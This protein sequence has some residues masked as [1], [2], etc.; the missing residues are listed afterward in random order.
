MPLNHIGD[1]EAQTLREADRTRKL[2]ASKIVQ[3]DYL[4]PILNSFVEEKLF[5]D[6]YIIF[7]QTEADL[8][9][10]TY[11]KL[12]EIIIKDL[13]RNLEEYEIFFRIVMRYFEQMEADATKIFKELDI[14]LESIKFEFKSKG[15]IALTTIVSSALLA[16]IGRELAV[17]IFGGILLTGGTLGVAVAVYTLFDGIHKYKKYK[18]DKTQNVKW[19]KIF[20]FAQKKK[21]PS[22]KEKE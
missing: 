15:T 3:W 1:D 5:D 4:L 7:N 2:V 22:K 17:R 8:L 21:D 9:E 12:L 10:D 13:D 19:T 20:N 11:S 16:T 14:D 6:S 18:K